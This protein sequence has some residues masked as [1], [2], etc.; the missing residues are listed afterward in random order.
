MPDQSKV[1][2]KH[3]APLVVFFRL[4]GVHRAR[5][6]RL[7]QGRRGKHNDIAL[8][9]TLA[10]MDRLEAHATGLTPD[11]SRAVVEA[12]RLGIDPVAVLAAAVRT[13]FSEARPEPAEQVTAT[14]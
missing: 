7:T 13:A 4:Y 11:E 6:L 5:M 8:D 2:K 14:A 1:L 3:Q 12:R 10:E 9:G